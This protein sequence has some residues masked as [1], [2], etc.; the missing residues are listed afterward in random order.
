MTFFVSANFQQNLLGKRIYLDNDFLGTLYYDEELLTEIFHY[1]F[2]QSTL[3]IDPLTRFEFLR[4]IFIDVTN[5]ENFILQEIF[6]IALNHPEI[7][8]KIQDN[9]L[10]LSKIYAHKNNGVK[11]SLV[12][13]FLAG[14]IMLEPPLST[15]I[16]TANKKDFPS[17]IFD[18][19]G[20]IS[21]V[22][23]DESVQT[24]CLL[25]FNQEK[26]DKAQKELKK[27]S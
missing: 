5:R 25:S 14:R 9:A 26:F 2:E 23:K 4:S 16:I 7:F 17:C 12:D 21:K 3:M 18:I 27:I 15:K 8:S 13:L 24:Y 1:T 20:T 10:I 11:A 6:V 22:N 19:D